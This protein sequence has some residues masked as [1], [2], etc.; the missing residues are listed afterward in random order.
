MENQEQRISL[1]QESSP[2]YFSELFVPNKEKEQLFAEYKNLN[3]IAG[4]S[5]KIKINIKTGIETSNSKDIEERRRIYGN[6]DPIVKEPNTLWEYIVE[7]LEDKMLRIL[8]GAA[9]ISTIIG[10][11]QEGWR[12]GWLEGFA[13]FFA[14]FV[15][16]SITSVNNYSKE[17]Q[18]ML[19]SLENQKKQVTVRRDAIDKNIQ[20]EE[21]V[22]GDVLKI[23]IG[24]IIPVDGI[25]VEGEVQIDE[26]SLTGESDLVKKQNEF[27]INKNKAKVQGKVITPVIFS[28]TSVKQGSG[29]MLVC[30]VGVN[31]HQGKTTLLMQNEGSNELTPLQEKL[32]VLADK[33]SDFGLFAA[34]VIGFSIF[35]KESLARIYHG[36][37]IFSFTI[38]D[39][40]TN[41]FIMAVAVIVVAIPEG[42]PLAVA[43]S[44][45][46]SVLKLKDK[47]NLVRH[48]DSAETMGGVQ[49]ICSDK[50]GTLTNGVMTLKDVYME[51]KKINYKIVDKSFNSDNLA[52]LYKAILNNKEALIEGDSEGKYNVSGN[53]TDIALVQ[54]MIDNKVNL[55]NYYEYSEVE[56]QENVNVKTLPFNS[57]YKMMAKFYRLKDGNYRMYVKGAPERLY[58]RC[59]NYLGEDNKV[60]PF[61]SAIWGK[62]KE[63][64]DE[65]AEQSMR[66]IL[67]LYSNTLTE[68]EFN[69]IT[70][71]SFSNWENLINNLTI[72]GMVGIADTKRDGVEESIKILTNQSGI[73][74]KMVTGDNILTAIAI[75]KDVGILDDT[76]YKKA[77]YIVKAKERNKQRINIINQEIKELEYKL[78]T[79]EVDRSKVVNLKK[80]LDSKSDERLLLQRNLYDSNGNQIEDDMIA[81]E[82][83]ELQR[84]TGGYKEKKEN[85]HFKPSEEAQ[86]NDKNKEF[87]LN[88]EKIF[89]KVVKNLRVIARAS[90]EDK[91]LL[92]L[93]LKQ[94]GNVVA[95]TGD[96]TNDA[97]ALRVADVGFAMGKRGT[98]IC[99]EA[100]DIVILNDSFDSIVTA[101]KY[102][103]NVFDCI[104]K[105]LQFQLTT[106]VVAVLMTFIGGIFLRD[107]PLN[108]IQMLWV[109]L[110]MDSFAS[111]ALATEPPNNDL[112]NRKPYKRNEN[113]VTRMMMYNVAAQSI[114]QIV[115]LCIIL[116]Y[117]DVIFGVPSDRNLQHYKW[118]NTN[119]Y[120]FTIFF[121]IF[122]FMQVFNSINARKL[123]KNEFNIFENINNN[124]LYILVQLVIVGGQLALVTFGGRPVRTHP[125]S[126]NQHIACMLIAA[127]CIP[128]GM[129]IKMLPFEDSVEESVPEEKQGEP[130]YKK[131]MGGRE[132]I[133]SKSSRI[134]KVSLKK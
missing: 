113:M 45:A 129:V 43:I 69:Q 65:F 39:T 33:I 118:N 108:A 90:P 46:Y 34:I 37:V 103:R 35:F 119:G 79:S 36:N 78:K 99:K 42:L 95:V 76:L 50:T 94:I 20:I 6:N 54:A 56:L 97:P 98:D 73:N 28:G 110:I 86:S 17:K 115:V 9:L 82:G 101:V 114:F 130:I 132:S 47:N 122:V 106:N 81:M 4:I 51:L 107:A 64:Q 134:S 127:V 5:S 3:G 53:M 71:Q 41:A 2:E 117:G 124:P 70:E 15:V 38:F 89:R 32:K 21:L 109:N 18:F 16:V 68:N 31:S 83:E 13:I 55:K 102:G 96:G 131:L 14:V 61:T 60:I 44:L 123:K 88:N 58:D 40:L 92:V 133:R 57:E 7:C 80:E 26:S 66:T 1:I 120:H 52:L 77:L 11:I 25:M 105:F 67:F 62:F 74:V 8:L 100:S 72:V 23:A 87:V 49:Q 121:N 12:T 84:L 104:R 30:A 19:L 27:E 24:N 22:V 75:A 10:V 93:G 112:L 59:L 116:A 63:T 85:L 111:L 128:F 48:M 126:I 125:L 29:Y 91:Y